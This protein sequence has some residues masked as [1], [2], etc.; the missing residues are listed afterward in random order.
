MPKLKKKS[1]R[2]TLSQAMKFE[3]FYDSRDLI[4]EPFPFKDLAEK[5]KTWIENENVLLDEWI[6]AHNGA[7]RRPSIWYKVHNPGKPK[8]VGKTVLW[9]GRTPNLW[10]LRETELQFLHRKGC[11]LNFEL[12]LVK[13]RLKQD[14]N[15][16]AALLEL[17]REEVEKLQKAERRKALKV[18]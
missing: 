17:H 1:K 18:I 2:R 6:L 4:G 15:R 12:E 16:N 10:D 11:L 14:K 5:E 7:G 13:D 3:M 8:V 9:N